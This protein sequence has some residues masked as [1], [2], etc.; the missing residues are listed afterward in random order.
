MNEIETL[1]SYLDS[2]GNVPPLP[3]RN[4]GFLEITGR[5][6]KEVTISKVYTY[7][8]NLENENPIRQALRKSLMGLI[9]KKGRKKISL[10]KFQAKT[11]VS[12]AQQTRIDIL[13][14]D[15]ENKT[16]VIIENKIN[17]F[18]NNDLKTY[19]EYVSYPDTQKVGVLLTLLPTE[20]PNDLPPEIRSGYINITHLEWIKEAEELLDR[21]SLSPAMKLYFDDFCYTLNHLTRSFQMNEKAKFYFENVEK[22]HPIKEAYDEAYKYIIDQLRTLAQKIGEGWELHGE[23]RTNRS[24]QN[25]K[26]YGKNAFYT[27]II[28]H[29]IRSNPNI[30][31]YLD[32]QDQ[33]L[34]M[35]QE[36]RDLL[37][38]NPTFKNLH[39]PDIRAKSWVHFVLMTYDLNM[40]LFSAETDNSLADFLH[41]KIQQDFEP[42]MNMILEKLN[43][44]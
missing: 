22:A 13:I 42:V 7:F 11:E 19:W 36:L 14:K 9:K 35:E 31:I 10:E 25:P 43:P 44:S 8:L 34:Q 38:E 20:I 17:H 21:T 37:R 41:K 32:L 30:T 28:Y 26:K 6:S 40:S 15:N 1:K 33:G 18:L 4:I 3:Q 29:T 24:I 16:A 12:T 39:N 27:F 5:S 2:L 23:A